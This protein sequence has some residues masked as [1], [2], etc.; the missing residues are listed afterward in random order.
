[1][2]NSKVLEECIWF[3]GE[4]ILDLEG[5]DEFS[6]AK[7][8]TQLIKYWQTELIKFALGKKMLIEWKK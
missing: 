6:D 2:Q 5:G 8:K 4:Y 7:S 3:L 1:M